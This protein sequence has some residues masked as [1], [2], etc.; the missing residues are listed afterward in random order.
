MDINEKLK[1]INAFIFS[2]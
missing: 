1:N 2:I